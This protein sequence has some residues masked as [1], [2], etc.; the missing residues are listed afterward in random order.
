MLMATIRT[1]AHG[2]DKG[3]NRASLGEMLSNNLRVML[4]IGA[5]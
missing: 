3:L 5:K 2:G 1:V 4:L